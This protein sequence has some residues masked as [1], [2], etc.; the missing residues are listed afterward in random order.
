MSALG[1]DQ[2]DTLACP[3][4][5]DRAGRGALQNFHRL[6]V[7]GIEVRGA[8]GRRGALL[9]PKPLPSN[10][11]VVTVE[12]SIGT[13]ST[14][15]RGSPVLPRVFAPRIRMELDAPGSPDVE[16]TS[17]LGALADRALTTLSSWLRLMSNEST[18]F[19]TLPSFS[20]SDRCRHP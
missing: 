14:T 4:A 16:V 2:D 18:L 8:V 6:D 1:G 17:T 5:V 10:V 15:K 20:T 12:L 3:G 19:R 9:A 11:V 13:P 7:C